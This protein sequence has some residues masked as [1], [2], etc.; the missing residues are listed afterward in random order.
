MCSFPQPG[1]CGL[2]T[3]RAVHQVS[4]PSTSCKMAAGSRPLSNFRF[5]PFG[6]TP[7]GGVCFH[8]E[9]YRICFSRHQQ[10]NAQ[11]CSSCVLQNGDIIILSVLFIYSLKC[12]FLLRLASH[13]LCYPMGQFIWGRY[14][15]CLVI[16]LL[17]KKVR[18]E[19]N[20][21]LPKMTN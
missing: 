4:L 19:D 17:K 5:D 13:L 15:K 11:I 14:H 1:F 12:Y 8:Q 9:A 7:G 3:H 2:H 6:K 18:F 10:L 21:H 16:F 20:K